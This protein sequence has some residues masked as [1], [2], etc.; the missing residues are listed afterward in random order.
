MK[1]S[2]ALLTL[3]AEA[4]GRIARVDINP[5]NMFIGIIKE[6]DH[7]NEAVILVHCLDEG[8]ALVHTV[9]VKEIGSLTIYSP[10]IGLQ[11]SDYEKIK[12]AE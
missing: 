9:L 2:N 7:K 10:F 1:I 5:G 4:V 6:V 3:L 8:D 12:E 11:I